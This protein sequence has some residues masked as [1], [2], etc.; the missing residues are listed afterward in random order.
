MLLLHGFGASRYTWRSLVAP[1]AERF[2]VIQ[3][4]L[5]GF[6][7]SPKPRDGA[8]GLPDHAALVMAFLQAR[9]LRGVIL[10]GHS[11][12]GSVALAVTLG[13]REREPERVR[14]LVLIGTPAYPQPVPWFIR[15]LQTPGVGPLILR[16]LPATFQVRRILERA[17]F[18]PGQIPAAAVTEYARLLEDPAGRDA[19]VETARQLPPPDLEALIDQYP[20]ITVPTLLL[21]GRH[22]RI[23]PLAIGER[24]ANA[25]P[26]AQLVVVEDAGHLPQEE[27]PARVLEILEGFL[28]GLGRDTD[29]R[30]N[31]AIASPGGRS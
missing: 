26:D 9:D 24:L 8:Y 15:L 21:W 27:T 4:D 6:G 12:G 30:P 25:L 28:D 16:A 7:Q 17:Y 2:T 31:R 1:L 14:A 29:R 13:L 18:D 11:F 5:K 10:V 19:L 20:T 3:L 23:V 22:D